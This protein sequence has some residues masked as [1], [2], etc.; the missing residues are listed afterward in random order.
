L[1]L[2]TGRAAQDELIWHGQVLRRAVRGVLTPVR[3]CAMLVG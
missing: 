2:T 3:G 1:L